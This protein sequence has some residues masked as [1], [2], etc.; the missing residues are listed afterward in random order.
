M[1]M[2]SGSVSCCPTDMPVAFSALPT[3]R[4]YT[5]LAVA[6]TRW[7][8]LPLT[9]LSDPNAD[10]T[11]TLKPSLTSWGNLG[12]WLQ[13][14]QHLALAL[15]PISPSCGHLSTPT[16]LEALGEQGRGASTFAS[17]GLALCQVHGRCSVD[18]FD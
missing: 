8:E 18:V 16:A 7:G 13:A 15:T 12:T 5:L 4:S 3:G 17:R 2:T 9:C 10:F 14:S 11:S 6:P 1:L